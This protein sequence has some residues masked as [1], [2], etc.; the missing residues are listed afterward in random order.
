MIRIALIQIAIMNEH[1][2]P[3]SSYK[4]FILPNNATYSGYLNSDSLNKLKTNKPYS[5]NTG[6]K[7]AIRFLFSINNID[8]GQIIDFPPTVILGFSSTSTGSK[9]IHIMKLSIP[10]IRRFVVSISYSRA[11]EKY[12]ECRINKDISN[13]SID[14]IIE[15]YIPWTKCSVNSF[16]IFSNSVSLLLSNP[17]ISSQIMKAANNGDNDSEYKVFYEF[18]INE[19]N[20]TKKCIEEIEYKK[21]EL[22]RKPISHLDTENTIQAIASNQYGKITE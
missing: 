3:F 20:E 21:A 4:G 11:I 17:G 5:D 13:Y 16:C 12:L 10:L 9:L 22:E 2:I 8:Y 7:G 14:V 18:I 6:W 1:L 15:K 19:L